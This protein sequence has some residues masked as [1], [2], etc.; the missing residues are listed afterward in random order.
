[1]GIRTSTCESGVSPNLVHSNVAG[2][3]KSVPIPKLPSCLM[4]SHSG[5]PPAQSKD[6]ANSSLHRGRALLFYAP[7]RYGIELILFFP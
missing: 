3:V 5:I 4:S 7:G 6:Q 1:V 2:K